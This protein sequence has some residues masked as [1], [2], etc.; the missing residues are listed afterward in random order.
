MTSQLILSIGREHGSGGHE[1]AAI[2]ADKL[3]IQLFDTDSIQ[4]V[5][6][7][8]GIHPE[9]M[10]RTDE[11]RRSLFAASGRG[12]YVNSLE[13]TVAAKTFEFLL[14]EAE[15]GKS[16]VIVG[17]AADYVLRANPNLVRLFIC[18]QESDKLARIQE[19]YGLSEKDAKKRMV[20]VDRQRKSYH[21]YFAETT[22]GDSRYYDLCINSSGIELPE[23]ADAILPYLK[24]KV[25]S[26]FK[27]TDKSAD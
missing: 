14:K 19:S 15:A 24:L 4:K 17:R 8:E 22:W 9:V 20:R 7:E 1:L 23:L 26:A 12:T 11:K 6:A 16:F 21:N 5:L 27:A 18:G 25:P 3:Q 2:L 13:D 10:K